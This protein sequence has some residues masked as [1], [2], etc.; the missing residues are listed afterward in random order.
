MRDLCNEV[1]FENVASALSE[2]EVARFIIRNVVS[3]SQKC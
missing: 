1:V 3:K 2:Q